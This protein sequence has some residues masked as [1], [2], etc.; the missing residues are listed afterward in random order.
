MHGILQ[1]LT[2]ASGLAHAQDAVSLE[3]VKAG[4]IGT[5]AP[6]L[7][8]K[9][10][11]DAPALTVKVD[12]GG[13]RAVH[14]GPARAGERIELRIDAPVGTHACKGSLFGRFADGSEGEM[15]LG[16]TVTVHPPMVMA[17]RPGSL[18]L[19]KRS[20]D[21]VMDRAT[22]KVEITAL[23]PKGVQVGYGLAPVGA[24]AQAPVNVEWKQ[25]GGEVLKL[26]IRAFDT[27]GFWSELELVPWS[28]SIPHEDVVFATNSSEIGAGEE[29]KLASAL[30]DARGVLDKYGADVVIKLYVGGHTDTVGDASSNQKLSMARARAI[31]GW[32][33]KS[34]FPGEIYYQG[35]GEGN[36][37]VD[38]GDEVDEP[39]NR[40]AS[41]TLA[42]RPPEA[43]GGGGDYGWQAL[44]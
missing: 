30:A 19:Q 28:Y 29:P 38:A 34:G 21:V 43:S 24:S 11:Q 5:S 2:L 37:A 16:F 17:L 31:A 23:G 7:V 3:V 27:D 41:Y 44:K 15:P 6:G 32:F 42:A 18:D 39:R 14:D 36:L 20:L 26:L 13:A 1:L 40:R 33:K 4:Q 25:D 9:M 22:S 8:L 12:C 35:Y 10:N